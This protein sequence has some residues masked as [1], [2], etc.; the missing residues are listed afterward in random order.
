MVS[1]YRLKIGKRKIPITKLN[2]KNIPTQRNLSFPRDKKTTKKG[3]ERK[4]DTFCS[5]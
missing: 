2:A 5:G 3:A 1:I 4:S